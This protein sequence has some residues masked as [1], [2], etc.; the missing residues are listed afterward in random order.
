MLLGAAG[1]RCKLL[2]CERPLLLQRPFLPK[3]SKISG[4]RARF[5][6]LKRS[7]GQM[8]SARRQNFDHDYTQHRSKPRRAGFF[9]SENRRGVHPP[10][11]TAC[12]IPT[13]T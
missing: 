13:I 6:R 11:E 1:F 10:W 9:L 5:R 3:P 8:R 2:K 7:A 12:L 4:R